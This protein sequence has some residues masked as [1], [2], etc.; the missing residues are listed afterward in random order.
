MDNSTS[1]HNKISANQKEQ[2]IRLQD[3][4]WRRCSGRECIGTAKN[5]LM[6]H[7]IRKRGYFCDECTH[8]LLTAELAVR[9]SEMPEGDLTIVS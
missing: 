6:I 3:S 9:L 2:P 4:L 8:D 7:Y 1:K 5:L